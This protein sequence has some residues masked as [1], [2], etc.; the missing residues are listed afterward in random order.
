MLRTD[1]ELA[2]YGRYVTPRRLRDAGFEFS[3]PT[4]TGALSEIYG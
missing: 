1:P 3:H 2:L 4:L